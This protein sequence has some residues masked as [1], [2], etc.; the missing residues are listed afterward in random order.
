MSR[1]TA[2]AVC[3]WDVQET[4]IVPE[5]SRCLHFPRN[6]RAALQAIERTSSRGSCTPAAARRMQVGTA[7]SLGQAGRGVVQLFRILFV[8]F[9]PAMQPIAQPIAE[10]LD[11]LTNDQLSLLLKLCG[12]HLSSAPR[13]I[14][15]YP[16][17]PQL[18]H[19]RADQKWAIF[20]LFADS[21][22]LSSPLK[23]A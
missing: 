18:T 14:L 11:V 16:H 23:Q 19:C 7:L 22:L 5:A 6:H 21:G 4:T 9:S 3:S 2:S 8:Y 20:E 12:I 10:A 1:S 15:V 13:E 17:S